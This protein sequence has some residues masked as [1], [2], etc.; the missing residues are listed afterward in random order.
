MS[1]SIQ[2]LAFSGSLR[3]ASTNSG[4]LRVALEVVPEGMKI[5][6]FDL[7]S[8]PFYNADVEA[9]AVPDSV[10]DFKQRIAAA[11]ALLIAT[12][13]YNYSISGILKNAIDWASRPPKSTPLTRKPI[14]IMGAGGAMGTVRAQLHLRQVFGFSGALV[15]PKPELHIARAWEKFDSNGHLTDEKVKAEVRMLLEAL[16]IWVNRVV[17]KK[18]E[19]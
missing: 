12:P 17:Q 19:G 7:S 5:E 9:V 13:E 10:S 8:I 14:A 15:M 1:P 2:V 18:T 3:K 6:V 11:D 16:S 4:L